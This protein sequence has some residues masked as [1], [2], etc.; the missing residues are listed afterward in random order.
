VKTASQI[1]VT[2]DALRQLDA[3]AE[4]AALELGLRSVYSTHSE[5]SEAVRKGR[6]TASEA[7]ARIKALKAAA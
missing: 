1:E 6:M 4:Q 2:L 5:C 3:A 7:V